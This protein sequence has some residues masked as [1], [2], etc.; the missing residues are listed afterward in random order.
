M[1]LKLCFSN[2]FEI[3]G[4]FYKETCTFLEIKFLILLRRIICNLRKK[5]ISKI[6]LLKK[7]GRAV[8]VSISKTRSIFQHKPILTI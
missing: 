5:E 2:N 6:V 8:V 4:L 3:Q 7:Y 1:D